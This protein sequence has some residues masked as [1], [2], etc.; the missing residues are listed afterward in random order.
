MQWNSS[1]YQAKHD[2]V[3]KYGEGVIELLQPQPGER[4]LD[5]GCGTGDLTAHIAQSGARVVGLDSSPDMIAAARA[6]FAESDIEFVMADA[7]DFEF[8]EP[9][10]AIFSNAALHWV[11][12]MEG[13]VACM[14]R[15]LKPGGRFV[16]ELGGRGNI[17]KLTAAIDAAL[18]AATGA[19]AEHGRYYPALGEYSALLEK[20]GVEVLGAWLFDRPTPLTDGEQGLRHWIEQFEQAVLKNCTQAQRD[21]IVA[22]TEDALRAEFFIEGRWVTDYRRLRIEGRKV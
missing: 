2:F 10:D 18:F 14:A 15:A 5:V 9:F 12:D 6:R 11:K 7:A 22:A 4:I 3:F 20:H 1:L 16:V 8:D 17:A 21:A 13:A 19:H